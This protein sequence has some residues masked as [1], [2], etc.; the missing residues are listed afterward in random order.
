VRRRVLDPT[1]FV[2]LVLKGPVRE[3]SV[4]WRRVTVRPVEIKRRRSLQFSWWDG[5]RDVTKNHSGPEAEV[6]LDE[7]LA[8][9]FSSVVLKSA[10]GDLD[11]RVTKKGKVLV[12]ASPAK[13]ERRAAPL[14]HDRPKHMPLLAGADDSFLLATGIVDERGLVRPRMHAKYTQVNEFIQL[15]EHTGE[16]DYDPSRPL[17]IVDCGCGSAYLT[18]ATY[19]YLNHV[20]NIPAAAVG[21]DVNGPLLEKCA[22]QRD[23]LG[24]EGVHFERSAILEYAPSDPPDIVIA[25]HAC[26]T[27]TD[28]ALAQGVRWGARV[29]LAAPCCH[30]DLNRQLDVRGPF[31]PVLR[32]GVLKQRTADILTDS[33]RAS[34]LR[35]LGY[36]TDVI[37]FVSTEHTAKN[38]MIRA[39]K[40]EKG[41]TQSVERRLAEEYRALKEYWEV[42]P[43]LE[44]LLGEELAPLLKPEQ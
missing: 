14:E 21:I 8:I 31:G 23:D 15:L 37:E 43:W 44:R 33:F 2:E 32:H 34:I 29:I 4:P 17:R 9:P 42:E 6:R 18:F 11:V 39:V 3:P 28:E 12:Q 30:H 16:L 22:R 7:A 35:I 41:A 5:K 27:A 20:R 26:D 19:H 25:L 1:S 40:T 10:D 24:Y 36:R 38:L 13:G